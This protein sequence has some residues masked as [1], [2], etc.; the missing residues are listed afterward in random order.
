MLLLSLK[1]CC[2]VVLLSSVLFVGNRVSYKNFALAVNSLINTPYSLVIVGKS[3]SKSEKDFVYSKL[4]SD[5]VYVYSNINN[6]QLNILYNHAFCLLYP[7]SYEGFGIPVLEAQKSGCPVIAYNA[8]SIPE[9]IGDKTLLLNNL[10]VEE[11]HDMF[12]LLEDKKVRKR[13]IDLGL[14]N[15]KKYTWDNM[16]NQVINLY[17]K[18]LCL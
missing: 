2:W 15:S 12:H 18:A 8:S 17:K 3:L 11:V 1:E 6:K 13:I 16:Y 7:S 10:C 9:I 14:E 5:R 4:S